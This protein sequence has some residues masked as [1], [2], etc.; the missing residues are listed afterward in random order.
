MFLAGSSCS[1]IIPLGM[2]LSSCQVLNGRMDAQGG[3]GLSVFYQSTIAVSEA[4]QLTRK[5]S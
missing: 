5:P 3:P 4:T 2:A 1:N